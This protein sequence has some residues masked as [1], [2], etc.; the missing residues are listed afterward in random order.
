MFVIR[1]F[2]PAAVITM[3]WWLFVLTATGPAVFAGSKSALEASS[4]KVSIDILQKQIDQ[5][6]IFQKAEIKRFSNLLRE[7]Q[8]L[9]RAQQSA[10]S[11]FQIQASTYDNLLS[12]PS[13]TVKVLEKAWAE[14]LTS[15]AALNERQV[16]LDSH[17]QESESILSTVEDRIK[18][19][20]D[21][22]ADLDAAKPDQQKLIISFRALHKL[23]MQNQ[24]VVS[25]LA[26][27]YQAQI[28]KNRRLIQT[29]S[30][31]SSQFENEVSR[32]RNMGLFNRRKGTLWSSMASP[33]RSETQQLAASLGAFGSAA[34]WQSEALELWRLNRYFL[35]S[36]LVLF[37][38]VGFLMVRLKQGLSRLQER[39][40][41]SESP[42]HQ[43]ALTLMR[44][45]V[46]LAGMTLFFY[47]STLSKTLY[48]STPSLIVIAHLC[49]IWLLTRWGLD[50]LSL[51]R[52][53]DAAEKIGRRLSVLLLLIRY[54][55]SFYTLLSWFLDGFGVLLLSFRI[56]F[57]IGLL[58]WLVAFWRAVRR[59][60]LV[61]NRRVMTGAMLLGY[62]IAGGGIL[63]ELTGYER[64][65]VHWCLS[66]ALTAA[67]S[68]WWALLWGL[69]S[70]WDRGQHPT[71]YETAEE[72]PKINPITWILVRL[73]R[74]LWIA[75]FII[76]LILAWGGRQAVLM[77]VV[78][79][80]T[81]PLVIGSMTFSISGVL[82][83]ILVVL[84]T[85][86][87]TLLWRNLFQRRFLKRSG[88]GLGLQE[89]LT[90]LSVYVI[91]IFGILIAMHVFG[92]NTASL[93][94]AFGA[95]GIGL[96][97]GLQNIVSN[98]ISGI[99]LLFERPIQVGDR[100]EI[101]G[102]W[103]KVQKI[104]VRAT[105]VQTFDNASLIIPNA[106]FISKQ[107]T[108]WSFKDSKLRRQI[109]VGVAYGSDVE[110]V[111]DTLLEI[112]VDT[113]HV[114]GSP[115]PLVSFRDFGDS[116]LIFRLRV[117]TDLDHM[118]S[119]PTAIRFEID[120]LFKQRGIVIAF[121]QRDVHIHS[122]VADDKAAV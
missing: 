64:L 69:L 112:A 63:L 78:Q 83:A 16:K 108:N 121:P 57:E 26:G 45:S 95:I 61:I 56:V 21:R 81:F 36:Y 6:I 10:L 32:R 53:T 40:F 70:D 29:F 2:K 22:M 9:D 51:H 47:L 89:S 97:F 15:L 24:A 3:T 7:R 105:V 109:D 33:L 49:L 73:G 96:G 87:A 52:A 88:M 59:Q 94:V 4:E 19:Q 20:K 107:V 35:I 37:G 71:Q 65:A 80:L 1:R 84:A 117:W 85:Q 77:Q 98:F 99:I 101:D 100:I 38:A 11:A 12:T 67:V 39:A 18:V 27:F 44:H 122:A 72:S 68:L 31:L 104:N 82:Y 30:T 102:T 55:A 25:K 76:V 118:I 28:T 62:I 91:W 75:S 111:R 66:W 13:I 48:L 110:L 90:T 46:L 17:A 5:A 54:T 119:V 14:I 86:A 103:G 42:M 58:F 23:L 114:M 43:T 120:R 74:V 60:K 8:S 93:A 92:L 34:Y 113:P 79:I 50:Y 115:K 106:D 116:A 41:L